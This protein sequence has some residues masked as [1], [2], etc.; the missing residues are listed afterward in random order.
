MFESKAVADIVV[1]VPIHTAYNQ[2]TQFEEFPKFMAAVEDALQMGDDR[3]HLR[4]KIAGHVIEYDASITE[5]IPDQ[6][7]VWESDDDEGAGGEIHFDALGERKTHVSISLHYVPQGAVEV[8]GD[9]LGVVAM[10]TK[11]DLRHFKK[12]IEARGVETGGWRGDIHHVP[13]AE[14]RPPPAE[15]AEPEAPATAAEPE[16]PVAESDPEPVPEGPAPQQMEWTTQEVTGWTTQQVLDAQF[17]ID[18][19]L[20]MRQLLVGAGERASLGHP[21][22]HSPSTWA[23]PRQLEGP[24]GRARVLVPFGVHAHTARRP[25]C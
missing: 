20:E 23:G 21:I 2:W 22:A 9:L 14:L 19:L 15:E 3:V 11:A 13:S 8:I 4:M 7:I 24:S 10:Q 17:S 12:F 16:A 18:E 5:Q 1:N 6:V 25:A